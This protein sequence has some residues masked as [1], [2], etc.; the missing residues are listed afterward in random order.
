MR[1]LKKMNRARAHQRKQL[2]HD[3][4]LR[5]LTHDVCVEGVN[6]LNSVNVAGELLDG[7]HLTTPITRRVRKVMLTVSAC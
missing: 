3:I 2:I 6:D 4:S 7:N 1:A 5:N